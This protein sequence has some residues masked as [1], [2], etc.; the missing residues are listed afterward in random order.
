MPVRTNGPFFCLPALVVLVL[1]SV[2]QHPQTAAQ[3]YRGL[4]KKVNPSVV[5]I[6]SAEIVSG[7]QEGQVR[8]SIGT[9]FIINEDGSI[10]TAAHVV[11]K[12]DQILVKFVDGTVS[13]ANVVSSVRAADVALIKVDKL[14]ANSVIAKLGDSDKTEPGEPSFVIGNPFGIEHSLSIGHISGSQK[15]PVI[16]SGLSLKVIQTDAS[17][18]HGNSGGPLFNENGEVVGVVSH[19]L[20]EGGG[21]DGIGF[22]VAINEAKEILLN[23][24]PIWTGFEGSLLTSDMAKLLNVPQE[25]ALLV[26]NVRRNSIAY[27]AGLKGGTELIRFRGKD[28]LV[29]GDIILE[30]EDKSCNCEKSISE[31]RASLETLKS[32]QEV[33]VKILR[34][35]E[36][37]VLKFKMD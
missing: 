9:G 23:Q 29:G 7:A 30:I 10:M 15:R 28:I 27:K 12:S 37:V 33:K 34:A 18:N 21:F 31:L 20:S 6:Q 4:Y 2:A 5:T 35:G 25:S 22:A 8:K 36:A 17:I 24:S 1:L 11:H 16:A 14:P 19:I 3:D 26:Q 13:P 32:G